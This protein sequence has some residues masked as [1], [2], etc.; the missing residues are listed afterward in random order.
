[1]RARLDLCSAGLIKN[2]YLGSQMSNRSSSVDLYHVLHALVS[3][4]ADSHFSEKG[5]DT[6]RGS[7]SD[8]IDFSKGH[9]VGAGPI[10][11]KLTSWNGYRSLS[12]CDVVC[13]FHGRQS[14]AYVLL[15]FAAQ[16]V[17]TAPESVLPVSSEILYRFLRYT[18]DIPMGRVG[19]L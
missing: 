6:L 4:N 16:I 14:A 17:V 10:D 9:I 5:A 12:T 19:S 11:R 1:L 7:S 2:T 3:F 18:H 15:K 13:V 8:D